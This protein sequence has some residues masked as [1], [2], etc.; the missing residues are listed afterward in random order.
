MRRVAVIASASGNGKTTLGRALAASLEVP[1]VELDGLVHGPNWVEASDGDLRRALEPT[2][3]GS[4]WVI[5]GTYQR[6]IGDLVLASADTVV[7]LDLP[8][9]VWLPRLI[10]RTC[11]RYV[12]REPLW[13]GNRESLRKALWGS[14][15]LFV[16]A[17]K[18]HFRRRREWPTSLARYRVVRLRKPEDVERFLAE[19]KRS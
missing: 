4:G 15:S 9:A 3:A 17:F 14:E 7:W 16:F 6:K 13:N 1:F 18:S 12:S 19:A 10:G 11:R 2:L 5:D 8:M